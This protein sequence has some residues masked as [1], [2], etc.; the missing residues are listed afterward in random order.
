MDNTKKKILQASG[1]A[2]AAAV[3]L[4]S[5]AVTKNLV[6]LALDRNEPKAAKRAGRMVSGTHGNNV[7]LQERAAA[8]ERLANRENEVVQILSHDG[9]VLTGHWFEQKNAKRAIIAVHGWRSSWCSDFGMTADFWD[10]N[11]C[12]VLYIEQ[13]GQNNSGG[14][15]M[16]LGMMERYDCLDW[17]HW[18]IKRCGEDMPIYLGGISMGATTV[19]MATGLDLPPN[20]RAVVGDCGYT[21]PRAIAKHVTK[22]N[23]HMAFG[24]R[25]ALANQMCKKKI[26]IGIDDYS[27]IDAMKHCKV[28]VL[29]VHGE[30]DHFVPVSMTYENYEACQAPKKLLIV[31]GADHG[32]SYY[33]NKEAYEAAIQEIWAKYD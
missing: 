15:Y 29:F 11:N 31:P 7:F 5:Y 25:G 10:K 30:Q 3:S 22:N 2:A 19:L 20:V 23:L 8:A 6:D 24:M 9:V 26:S 18:V 14:A 27:T 28:P 17:I 33:L 1:V 13:R 32:M 21:S 12:N 16:G 4:T